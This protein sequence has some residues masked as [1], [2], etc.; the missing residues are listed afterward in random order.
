VKFNNRGFGFKGNQIRLFYSYEIQKS[1]I[2]PFLRDAIIANH[3]MT[4]L[5]K[6]RGGLS[7]DHRINKAGFF[8][9]LELPVLPSVPQPLGLG[10][11]G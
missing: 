10:M 5:F 8:K 2:A 4:S 11:G 6:Q 3:V 7:W 1:L 9:I